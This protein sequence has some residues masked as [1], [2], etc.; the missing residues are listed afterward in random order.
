[1][2]ENHL[3]NSRE[4]KLKK[5][6]EKKLSKSKWKKKLFSCVKK[7]L[8]I[9]ICFKKIFSFLKNKIF[10]C[11]SKV[12]I[13]IQFPLLLIPV[14]IIMIL[15]FLF[16]YIYFYSNLYDFNFSK[17]FKEEFHD[18]YISKINDLK[19]DI[20]SLV[21]KDT[22]LDL[23][24][25][26]FFQVYFKELATAGLLDENIN[27]FESFSDN[28]NS[29]SI[30][31]KLNNINNVDVNFC[32]PEEYAYEKIDERY[33]D[34]LG[35]FAKIYYYMFPHIWYESLQIKPLIN[36]SFLIAYEMG[37]TFSIDFETWEFIIVKGM[38][39]DL[40][41]FRFPKQN[42]EEEIYNNYAPN[43]YLL[44][45]YVENDDVYKEWYINM[46]FYY[47]LNW[48]KSYDYH[49]RNSINTSKYDNFINI[50]FAHLNKESDH[51]INKT[52]ITYASQFIKQDDREYIIH[53]VFFWD[54]INLKEG[55]NDFTFLIVQDNFT[56]L[57][58]YDSLIE[59]FSDN[60][61][62]VI[63]LSD[64]TEYSL[65]EIDFRLFHLNLYDKDYGL[66]SH[67]ILYDCFNLD[68]FYDYSKAYITSS[69]GKHDLKYYVTLYL[70]KSLFQ[71]VEYTKV[72]NNRD[73]IFLYNF[74]KGDN[75]KKICEKINFESYRD[76]L[77][78]TGIDCWNSKNKLYYNIE[79]FLYMAIN[80]DSN[81]IETIYPYCSCLPLYCLKNYEDLVDKFDN[82]NITDNINLPNKCQNKFFKYENS[83]SNNEY[84]ANNKILD[85]IDYS[86]NVINYDY[87]KFNYLPLNQLPG[88]CLFIIS[89]IGTTGEVYI[90]IYYK[91]IT[92]IEII[93]I[94]IVI[95][96]ISSILNIILIYK[97]MKQYSLMISN[98]KKKFE[99][100]IFHSENEDKPNSYN[101]L[102][103][104][105][106]IKKG[107]KENNLKN[108]KNFH[109]LET[110]SLISKDLF[111][112][113]DNN[114]LDDLFLLFSNN[115]NI[116]RKDIGKY[117][118]SQRH[119][120]KNLMKL[121][122][123]KEKNELFKLL[124]LFC[125][126]APFFK[127][128]LNFDFNMYEYSEIIKKYNYYIRKL[129][130]INN[131]QIRLT[132][133][134]LNELIST[135]CIDDYGLIINF[136]FGYVTNIKSDSKK[137]SIKYT[138]FEY[139]KSHLKKKNLKS[140][141]LTQEKENENNKKLILKRKNVLMDIFKRKFESDEYLNDNKLNSFFNFFLI[142]SYYKYLKQITLG[143]I[144]S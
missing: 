39:S 103:I 26:L 35:N 108:N 132:Q 107:Q 93:I 81:T 13:Y 121:D 89:Q 40:L 2:N 80:N 32:I 138:M 50:S 36:Q 54:Q 142:N 94:V 48:F 126:Y 11:I 31:S 4:T 123:M 140:K 65:S 73:E 7:I 75:V 44:N 16:I 1:M 30:Y 87:I 64:T 69:Q 3:D 99:F 17:V 10:S 18:L 71:N 41:Y 5:G 139:I 82:L 29:T 95:L 63:S 130:N 84:P 111:I 110:N 37:D 19:A 70:Y 46:N 28:P 55:E 12:P 97:N 78:Y 24:K 42:V 56:D 144:I 131:K 83:T 79:N 66:Y 9:F 104:Y 112:I 88:Y 125:L 76:Y 100:Y 8:N 14:S 102:N 61:S 124:S 141:E 90:H 62:Y 58:S 128:D 43:D 15:I 23:E 135:E 27:F 25:Q 98:F 109:T 133:N 59:R 33:G 137:N 113:N 57:L 106:R 49:F 143:N 20:T 51:N 118:S 45:P 68:Y 117:Y 119:K 22:K 38:Y 92:K 34:K 72:H 77:N 60:R 136:E 47:Y 114:L 53:I 115:Y 91:L 127:L 101:N 52:F 85:L 129:E 6:E 21:V 134:I 96:F 122:M 67:G 74:K 105:T 116:S 86:S 120:S